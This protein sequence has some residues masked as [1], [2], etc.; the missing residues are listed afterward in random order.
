M[1]KMINKVKEFVSKLITISLCM[2]GVLWLLER[3]MDNVEFPARVQSAAASVEVEPREQV[4]LTPEQ[5]A[6]RAALLHGIN[7]ALLRAVVQVESRWNAEAV[8]PKGAIGYAQIMPANAKRCG[9]EHPGKLW[10][11]ELN[12]ACGAQILAE[13]LSNYSLDD[14]LRVYNGGPRALK[15]G[16]KES[17]AYVRKVQQALLDE[18]DKEVR[19]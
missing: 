5:L 18:L 2:C 19:G 8:S 10:E 3:G 14:A 11:P 4:E 17:E 12:L 16:F 13:E 7:P 9:Y 15:R 1:K 6:D